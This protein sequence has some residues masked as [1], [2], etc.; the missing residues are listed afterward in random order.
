[1][2]NTVSLPPPQDLPGAPF[3]DPNLKLV[4]ID[5]LISAGLIDLGDAEDFLSQILGR[6]YDPRSD[7]QQRHQPAYDYLARY[8]LTS[9][10]LSSIKSICFDAGNDI[11]EMIWPDW[12][13]DTADFNVRSLKGI[14]L[15]TELKKFNDIST[16][17]VDDFRTLS[18][19][20]KLETLDLGLGTSVP[21]AVLL[22]LPAL[23]TFKC[24]EDDAPDEVT[25]ANLKAKGV[26][27]RLY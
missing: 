12:D 9:D 10:Q 16:L 3:A 2:P 26:G 21:A 6:P 13:G 23:K 25:I 20:P 1:M 17:E 27:I 18:A 14:E 24:Y 22:N 19:L 4:V 7:G 15:L 8:P 11:Y 5:E